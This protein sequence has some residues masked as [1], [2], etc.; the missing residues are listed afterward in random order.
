MPDWIGRVMRAL[1]ILSAI[2][3]TVPLAACGPWALYNR[4][5]ATPERAALYAGL[6]SHIIEFDDD[7]YM[8]D[9]RQLVHTMAALDSAAAQHRV[10]VLVFIHGWKNNAKATNRNLRSFDSLATRV[11]QDL[12]ASVSDARPWEVVPVYIG[13]RGESAWR[14]A[15]YNLW[16]TWP[17]REA[18]FFGRK[19]AAERVGRGE[20]AVALLKISA[21]WRSW[22]MSE[23]PDERANSLVLMGHSFGAAALFA[24]TLPLLTAQLATAH[25]A[26]D[27]PQI[28]DLLVAI[29]P[30]TEAAQL[31]MSVLNPSAGFASDR[32]SLTQLLVLDAEDDH[33]RQVMFP[34]GRTVGGLLR[35]TTHW[36]PEHLAAAIPA[37]QRHFKLVAG[38]A[39]HS[40]DPTCRRF[41][42]TSDTRSNRLAR[43]ELAR[44]DSTV[45]CSNSVMVIR[46]YDHVIEGHSGIWYPAMRDFLREFVEEQQAVRRREMIERTERR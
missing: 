3:L 17:W 41:Y 21:K 39:A 33:A 22:R 2:S 30:A 32:R 6:R 12:N 27:H 38:S 29:N 7:G 42:E 10:V 15:W 23:N 46:T 8:R 14:P 28:A 26:L 11:Q 9:R 18:T 1:H 40:I 4:Q 45:G 16:L 35:T 44:T 31:D 43:L 37:S 20:F 13:W 24:A 19:E 34:L 5:Y 36:S 25:G